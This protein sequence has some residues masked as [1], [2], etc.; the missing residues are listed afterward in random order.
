[1][2]RLLR[3]MTTLAAGFMLLAAAAQAQVKA[4]EA[5]ASATP[6]A[7][8]AIEPAAAKVLKAM[9]DYLTNAP[10]LRLDVSDTMDI[11]NDD[12]A[13]IQYGHERT[14]LVSRP[15]KLQSI[16]EG[17]LRHDA[18]FYD[19]KKLTVWN[20][21]ENVYAQLDTPPT[22]Q[23]TLAMI[24]EKYGLELPA[25]DIVVPNIYEQIEKVA[26][27]GRYVGLHSVD[28]HP[29][30][31]ILLAGPRAD[32]Q[33]WIDAGDKPVPR[34]IVISYRERPG[35]P[36]CTLHFKSVEAPATLAPET[37]MFE[38]PAGAEKVPFH[39]LDAKAAAQKAGD[40]AK[41]KTDETK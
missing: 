5:P 24:R 2:R 38:P 7:E 22:I 18:V 20:P 15:D 17:D 6:A 14:I 39:P 30:H 34:K 31:H 37:F 3:L 32:W 29:C 35:H 23:E 27:E 28:G 1:M 26:L 33:L 19:G 21:S 10:H 13:M 41:E 11:M 12:G 36:Q 9:S 40:K 25:S 16:V 8:P 4:P